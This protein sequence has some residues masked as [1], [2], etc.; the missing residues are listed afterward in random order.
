MNFKDVYETFSACTSRNF[1]NSQINLVKNNVKL[2]DVFDSEEIQEIINNYEI[3]KVA[4]RGINET[5]IKTF[6]RSY[7]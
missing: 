5:N 4:N 7:Q 1:R 6:T 2:L 3:S